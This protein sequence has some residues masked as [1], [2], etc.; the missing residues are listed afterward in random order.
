MASSL[1]FLISDIPSGSKK[2]MFAPYNPSFD[3]LLGKYGLTLDKDRV[4]LD[5]LADILSI[6]IGTARGTG[7]SEVNTASGDTLQLT[8]N[9]DKVNLGSFDL[10]S[11]LL[12][13]KGPENRVEVSGYWDCTAQ[14]CTRMVSIRPLSGDQTS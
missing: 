6:H 10:G 1:L 7:A 14:M 8:A 4:S 5:A 9:R 13:V 3:A 11:G 12:E 2:V